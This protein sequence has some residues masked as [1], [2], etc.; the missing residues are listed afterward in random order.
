LGH[1]PTAQEGTNGVGKGLRGHLCCSTVGMDPPAQVCVGASLSTPTH[2]KQMPNTPDDITNDLGTHPKSTTATLGHS[3]SAEAIGTQRKRRRK[4]WKGQME[5]EKAEVE[6]REGKGVKEGT[7]RTGQAPMSRHVDDRFVWGPHSSLPLPP[8]LLLTALLPRPHLTRQP[9][10]RIPRPPL[11]PQHVARVPTTVGNTPE[12]V[13]GPSLKEHCPHSCAH[14]CLP[15]TLVC[16]GCHTLEEGVAW[17]VYYPFSFS[18]LTF[19]LS[20]FLTS[21]FFT[22]LPIAF[23]PFTYSPSLESRD[24]HVKTQSLKLY[25]SMNFKLL[26]IITFTFISFTPTTTMSYL[27]LPTYTTLSGNA[28]PPD[29]TPSAPSLPSTPPQSATM[30]TPSI[31]FSAPVDDGHVHLTT[32]REGRIIDFNGKDLFVQRPH[33]VVGCT[34][35]PPIMLTVGLKVL[36]R[37]AWGKLSGIRSVRGDRVHFVFQPHDPSCACIILQVHPRYT[38]LPWHW[39]AWLTPEA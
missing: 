22:S 14:G 16:Q 30:P 25:S 8:L 20:L 17:S 26:H 29:L 10:Q 5:G 28:T 34:S 31:T 21:P 11:P 23:L 33:H 2:C 13:L 1:P 19:I 35:P 36:I 15:V 9:A 27:S 39:W 32:K 7:D 12:Q 6:E 3:A 4:R 18:F 24:I 38:R 37:G